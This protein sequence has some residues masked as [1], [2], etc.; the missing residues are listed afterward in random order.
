MRECQKTL[1]LLLH[2]GSDGSGFDAHRRQKKYDGNLT[3]QD[4]ERLQLLQ[5]KTFDYCRTIVSYQQ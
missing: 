3:F 4:H 2:F 1:L 5:S